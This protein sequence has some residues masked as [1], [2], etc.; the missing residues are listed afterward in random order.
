MARNGDARVQHAAA[1]YLLHVAKDWTIGC[2]V[3]AESSDFSLVPHRFDLEAASVRRRALPRDSLEAAFPLE[4]ITRPRGAAAWSHSTSVTLL[5]DHDSGTTAIEQEVV[6]L[7]AV[8]GD[9]VLAQA[10]VVTRI[11]GVGVC[12]GGFGALS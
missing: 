11:P 9:T 1:A 5:V 4:A 6:E 2:F 7:L 3:A 10:A 8:E 12:L